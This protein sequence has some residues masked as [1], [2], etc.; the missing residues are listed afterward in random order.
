MLRRDHPELNLDFHKLSS[1]D[2]ISD[3]DIASFRL[4]NQ[5]SGSTADTL[6]DHLRNIYTRSIG[7]EFMF[8]TVWTYSVPEKSIHLPYDTGCKGKTVDDRSDRIHYFHSDIAG[9]S[10]EYTFFNVYC[11][12]SCIPSIAKDVHSL[13]SQ[14]AAANIEDVVIGMP[15]RGRLNMLVALLDY[16]P[17]AIFSKVKGA[18]HTLES[19]QVGSD[20]VVSHI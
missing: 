17:R 8:I 1:S 13:L 7:A 14:A 4:S 5:F 19:G 3:E 10:E 11:T 18:S 20:D 12:C 2:I 16:P 6:L 15:H 9:S